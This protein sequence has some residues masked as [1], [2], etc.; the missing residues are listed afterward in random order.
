M[1]TYRYLI[2]GGGMTA[3]AA[4]KGIRELDPDG[5]IGVVT[6]EPY[7]PYARPPL[8]KATDQLVKI[9]RDWRATDLPCLVRPLASHQLTVPAKERLRRDHEDTPAFPRKDP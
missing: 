5:A 8:S 2:V 9:L 7:P 3:D 4:C 6:E 1:R